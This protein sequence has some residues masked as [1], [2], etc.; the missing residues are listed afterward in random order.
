MQA[1]PIEA[2]AAV[3]D[4][5]FGFGF[6]C[7]GCGAKTKIIKQTKR[8]Y[9]HIK[10]QPLRY[11]YGHN[12][13][14]PKKSL[15]SRFWPNVAIGGLEQCWEWQLCRDWGGYG[16]TTGEDGKRL[17]AHRASWILT[18]GK[19]SHLCILHQCD[20]PPCVNPCHLFLGTSEEN[21]YDRSAKG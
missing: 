10:G 12:V 17:T 8:M 1:H 3:P 18:R 16:I 14:H 11:V 20:N 2:P 19:D 15:A 6:C 4:W 5:P 9:G 13:S 21:S 7:C